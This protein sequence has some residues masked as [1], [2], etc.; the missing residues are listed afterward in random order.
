MA[1]CKFIGVGC[2]CMYLLLGK[3]IS[4]IGVQIF[5]FTANT[6]RALPSSVF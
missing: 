6:A 1:S 2:R 3:D 4:Q 5:F